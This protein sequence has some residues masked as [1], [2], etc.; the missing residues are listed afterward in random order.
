MN[1]HCLVLIGR[2]KTKL[3]NHA[4]GYLFYA[5]GWLAGVYLNEV[6]VETEVELPIFPGEYG[7]I[8]LKPLSYQQGILKAHLIKF[9]EIDCGDISWP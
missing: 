3:K 2:L 5:G 4:P 9:R 1:I 6:I 7:I 8:Y